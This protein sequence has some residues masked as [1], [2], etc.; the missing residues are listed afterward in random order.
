[1]PK[2]RILNMNMKKMTLDDIF[3][4]YGSHYS[5]K[6]HASIEHGIIFEIE[7]KFG[8]YQSSNKNA[9]WSMSEIFSKYNLLLKEDYKNLVEY[10]SEEINQLN[11]GSFLASLISKDKKEKIK[12]H[13]DRLEALNKV[14]T[15]S[16]RSRCITDQSA[17][18]NIY[19]PDAEVGDYLYIVDLRNKEDMNLETVYVDALVPFFDNDNNIRLKINIRAF[20]V[21][22][23]E[24][25]DINFTD[26]YC[27]P[28]E[29]YHV[30]NDR[31]KA[32]DFS[33][34]EL[35]KSEYNENIK[36]RLKLAKKIDS[37]FGY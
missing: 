30:F 23:V 13:Q 29:G 2:K 28:I 5:A 37:L 6:Y 26:N 35:M 19:E 32:Y 7:K 18:V 34:E 31:E 25:N 33:I 24:L 12:Y 17:I 10:H 4:T 1:M 3:E 15:M 14:F 36:M 16:E 11:K 20:N 21:D 22:K 9:Y 27:S 8:R